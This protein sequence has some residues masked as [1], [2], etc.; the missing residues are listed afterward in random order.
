MALAHTLE[1]NAATVDTET[2]PALQA[3]WSWA[4]SVLDDTQITRLSEL[5]FEALRGIC[6]HV[7]AGGGGLTPSDIAP[8]HLSQQQLDELCRHYRVADVLPLTPLQ[9]GLLFHARAAQASGDDV[10][11]VQLAITITGP[12]DPHRLREALHTVITR[13]PNLV[14]RFCEEFDEPVQIIPAQPQTPWRYV[15]LDGVDIDE[16]INQLCAAERAAVC[17]MA[18]QPA[19]RAALIRTA[20]DRHRF[21]LTNHHIVLDGWSMPILMREI[22]AAYYGQRLT[23]PV[24][25]RRFI[26]WLADR[27]FDAARAAWRHV[28]DGFDTPT[29]VGPADRLGLG[30]RGVESF[31]LPEE[32]TQAVVELARSQHTTVSTVLQAAFAQLLMWLTGQHD[33]AFGTVVSGR[34]A[35]LDGADSILGLLINT[36]PVRAR[37]TPT[38][39]TADLLDQ[40][41]NTHGRTLEH[42]HLALREIHRI[43]DQEQLFDTVFVYENYPID[44][45]QISSVDGLTISDLANRDCYHYPL[46]IQAVPGSEIG[47]RVQF[48]TDVF[49]AE[50]I[51]ALI[52]RFQRMLVT[53]TADPTRPL[54]T[55]D[56]LDEA[57]YAQLDGFGNQVPTKPA[58]TAMPEPGDHDTGGRYHGP[59]NLVEQILA[60]IYAQVLGIE[61]VGVHESFFDLGG[62]SLSAMRA[63]AAINT[64]LDIRLP[65]PALFDAPSVRSLSQQLHRHVGAVEESPASSRANDL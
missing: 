10:Y 51:E 17:E 50:S 49:D 31:R 29:L 44:P 57:E 37:I 21:V 33:V 28:L 19:F 48:R 32:T 7:R 30:R 20:P 38:T 52:D 3:G 22:F 6:A 11:A 63:I 24:P 53:M 1:L 59:A 62:D 39:S 41:Q 46:T 54:T 45:G 42:E 26:T 56:L 47:L 35:D 58:D 16:Q 61:R 43:A 12:L 23:A 5:W 2:G 13:H 4:P 8:A 18:D 34:P 27:D 65:V 9:Q 60:D 40:L 64:A 14:A 36:V 15:E 55:M 25:Y